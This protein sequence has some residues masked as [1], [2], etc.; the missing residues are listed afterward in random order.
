[1]CLHVEEKEG[2]VA[3]TMIEGLGHFIDFDNGFTVELVFSKS[4]LNG[5][6]MNCKGKISDV[7][8]GFFS[9][10]ISDGDERIIVEFFYLFRKFTM[11]NTCVENVGDV[12]T[13]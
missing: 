2:I 11:G 1:M 3:V 12:R 6:N 13:D 5:Y 4:E 7:F 9:K 8:L 10:N